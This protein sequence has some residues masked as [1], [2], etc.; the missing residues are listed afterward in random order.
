MTTIP[1]TVATP[2]RSRKKLVNS[3]PA[4][5]IAALQVSVLQEHL[6]RALAK[7]LHA[8]A[9]KSTMPILGHML[10]LAD[11]NRLTISATNLEIGMV[12]NVAA[13]VTR[14]GAIALPAKLL[15]DVVSSLPNETISLVMD[16]R[17]E[18]DALL[19]CL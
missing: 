3:V 17:H 6:K 13:T 19:H 1:T 7:A 11:G 9:P 4:P 12:V 2:P 15:S 14:H 16:A 8:V 5:S 18:C 10:L